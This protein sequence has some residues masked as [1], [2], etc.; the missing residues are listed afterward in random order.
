MFRSCSNSD[1][2]G[3]GGDGGGRAGG[4]TLARKLAREALE[5]LVVVEE[6]ADS[7]AAGR[8]PAAIQMSIKP[9]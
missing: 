5:R 8:L 9:Q 7:E 2:V 1:W 6:E 3:G 4:R